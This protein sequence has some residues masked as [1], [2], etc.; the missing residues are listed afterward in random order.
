VIRNTLIVMLKRWQS[1]PQLSELPISFRRLL[2]ILRLAQPCGHPVAVISSLLKKPSLKKS[3]QPL[4]KP[5]KVV[6]KSSLSMSNSW[7]LIPKVRIMTRN[8][9]QRQ[10]KISKNSKRKLTSNLEQLIII[11]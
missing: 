7:Q 11:N 8:V 5:L 2:W 3:S 10:Q 1:S 4:S 6:M 9:M